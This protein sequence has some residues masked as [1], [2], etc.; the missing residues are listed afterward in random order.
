MR[1]RS[2]GPGG[3]VAASK[4]SG[5]L[6]CIDALDIIGDR[7]PREDGGEV[8]DSH[9]NVGTG[10]SGC[11]FCSLLGAQGVVLPMSFAEVRARV[12]VGT[13]PRCAGKAAGL[14]YPGNRAG[15]LL[16]PLMTGEVAN[17]A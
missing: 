15:G 6:H 1:R 12:G 11:F 9:G 5:D 3:V 8:L 2:A 14:S 10:V 13:C 4:R 7:L 17:G 16:T